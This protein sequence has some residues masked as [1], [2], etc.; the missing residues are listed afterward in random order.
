MNPT[1][2]MCEEEEDNVQHVLMGSWFA[3]EATNLGL[4]DGVLKIRYAR[5]KNWF[6]AI[7]IQNDQVIGCC[8][9]LLAWA[10]WNAWNNKYHNGVVQDSKSTIIRALDYLQLFN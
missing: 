5:F 8:F 9:A 10:I 6:R 2:V 1:C 4:G 7:L 3:E